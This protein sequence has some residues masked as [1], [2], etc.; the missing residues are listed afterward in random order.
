VAKIW[1]SPIDIADDFDIV[2]FDLLKIFFFVEL[3]FMDHLL[4]QI[5][6]YLG[7]LVFT[8]VFKVEDVGLPI[9]E[10]TD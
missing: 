7:L 9:A 1:K 2:M 6:V 10:E 4:M 8:P 3:G 5:C